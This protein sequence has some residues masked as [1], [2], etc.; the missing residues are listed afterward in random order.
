[1]IGI[2][3]RVV[4]SFVGCIITIAIRLYAQELP[5]PQLP[6]LRAPDQAIPVPQVGAVPTTDGTSA[7]IPLTATLALEDL[8]LYDA[9]LASLFARSMDY[10]PTDSIVALKRARAAT[11]VAR[12]RA[13]RGS[14]VDGTQL[15]DFAA[16]ALRA[17]QDTLARQLIERRLAEIPAG[18]RGTLARSV[19]LA[20]AVA[21]FADPAQ[22]SV[23]LARNMGVAEQYAVQLR[24]IPTT[25]YVTQSDSTDILYRHL[26]A[27]IALLNGASAL[28]LPALVQQYVRATARTMTR[29]PIAERKRV[30]EKYPYIDV[31][32][33]LIFHRASH[34]M[35]DRAQ[36]DT[37]T[38]VLARAL[39]APEPGSPGALQGEG[40]PVNLTAANEPIRSIV[41]WLAL[42]GKP[43]PPISAHVWLNTADSAYTDVPRTH[44]FADG[45]VRVMVFD[46]M[47]S[48][49][50]LLLD[51]LHR[52]FPKDVQILFVTHTDGYLGLELAE[53]AAEVAWWRAYYRTQRHFSVPI[54][55]WGGPKVRDT[56]GNFVPSESPAQGQYNTGYLWRRC[57]LIDGAGIV[58][59]YLPAWSRSDE[60]IIARHLRALLDEQHDGQH[61]DTP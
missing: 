54:A 42:L 32:S 8:Q 4:P 1:V 22:D 29:L 53:P 3:F 28:R 57:V 25:G 20:A 16:I 59:E 21:T 23:R 33:A 49:A 30:L 50:L 46:N 48:P 34:G 26:Y 43:A 24:A 37:F 45:I 38:Q 39:G 36:L 55:I 44:R 12:L 47:D 60:V 11:W 14:G 31:A 52:Q 61:N 9:Q 5:P 19:T 6:G 15:L 40:Q 35:V 7:S 13:A 18:R 2:S 17:E 41:A 10:Y 27:D 56:Y 58:R 51:R